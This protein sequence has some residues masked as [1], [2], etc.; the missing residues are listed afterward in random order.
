MRSF[1]VFLLLAVLVA[2]APLGIAQASPV[3]WYCADS[4]ELAFLALI[5][6]Y[7]ASKGLGKLALG[8][9]I[10]AAAQHHSQDMAARDYFGH[11]TL[12]TSAGMTE[13]MRNHGYA[14]DT[15][16]HGEIIAAGRATA[17]GALEQWKNSP[18]HNAIMLSTKA[19]AIG[20]DRAYDPDSR[21]RYYWTADFG[22][23]LDEDA[24]AR[25]S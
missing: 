21:Y 23:V 13:R 10:G 20:V 22:G 6:D 15:T 17:L 5:N 2:A 18:G 3:R 19:K 4:S 7:R 8:R 1:R 25:C 14:V 9:Y 11:T 24:A 16:W 12:G